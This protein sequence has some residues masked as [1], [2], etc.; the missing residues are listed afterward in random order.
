MGG[1][2]PPWRTT[3][4]APTCPDASS[5]PHHAGNR[6]GQR[7][8]LRR[9]HADAWAIHHRLDHQPVDQLMTLSAGTRRRDRGPSGVGFDPCGGCDEITHRRAFV[10]RA[11]SSWRREEATGEWR[12]CACPARSA[13]MDEAAAVN[14]SS[15][16]AP[17]AWWLP[18]G[19]GSEHARGAGAVNRRA[20][21]VSR[22]S[23]S[24]PAQR[25]VGRRSG[26]QPTRRSTSVWM[27]WVPVWSTR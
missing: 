7:L 13:G 14:N 4:E 16:T 26:H 25:S 15:S 3:T 20:P 19:S 23:G 18:G 2:G 9:R 17:A 8:G 11:Q 27:R 1:D 5:P 10:Y 24:R 22:Q 6:V 21:V 12:S